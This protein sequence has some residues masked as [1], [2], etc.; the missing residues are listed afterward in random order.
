MSCKLV[1][2]TR[3]GN[4]VEA[5]TSVAFCTVVRQSLVPI[6]DVPNVKPVF[7]E[8]LTLCGIIHNTCVADPKSLNQSLN[9]IGNIPIVNF[10]Q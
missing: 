4:I 1:H 5:D 7:E 3:A 9:N 8:K 6:L 10:A 2:C